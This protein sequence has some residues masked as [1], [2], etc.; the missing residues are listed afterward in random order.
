MLKQIEDG[1]QDTGSQ[2]VPTLSPGK[3]AGVG[4]CVSVLRQSGD[5]VSGFQS[6]LYRRGSFRKA[7]EG[8]RELMLMSHG[9]SFAAGWW[10][11]RA[12]GALLDQAYQV[13][14]KIA[15]IHSE[16]SEAMEADRKGL[17]DDKLTHRA[18]IEVELAD[19]MIRILDL[20]GAL[21]LDLGGALVEK[22][23]FNAARADHKVENR[24]AVGGK[25]Y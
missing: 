4:A 20:A 14:I 12:T 7:Q 1:A 24:K 8:I 9:A 21:D 22:V 25:S 11:D 19:A 2:S 23:Q 18:G 6:L 16:I 13:P 5:P 17:A 3:L 10:H 15:L